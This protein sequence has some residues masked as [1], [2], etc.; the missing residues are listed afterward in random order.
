M[1][2]EIER[3]YLVDLAAIRALD[4]DVLANGIHIK[5]GYITTIDHTAV[6][7]RVMDDAAYLTLKG[8]NKGMTR[9]E[10]EYQI[11]PQEAKA[12]IETLCHGPVIDKTR[13]HLYHGA[14]LWELDIF[15]GD[16]DGLV[17]VEIELSQEAETFQLP[18]WVTEEVT[19]DV[20]YYNSS[21]LNHPFKNW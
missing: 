18:C 12:I 6:R 5:Q 21:L 16:N 11:P 10:F 13:Y 4:E 2:T 1:A 17:V 9:T 19:G 15:H 8:E 20:R 14:H 3:K 7:I